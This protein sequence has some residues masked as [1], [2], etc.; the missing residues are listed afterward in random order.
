MPKYGTAFSINEA[1][2]IA[3]KI[4]YPVLIRP[5]YVLGGRG[6]EIVYDEEGLKNFVGKAALVSGEHPILID[7]FLENAYEFDVDAISDGNKV[8]IAGIMQHIEE[9]GIHSGD[10]SCVYPPYNLSTKLR[11][12]IISYTKKL[13]IELNT[14]G[15]INIQFALKDNIIYVI[16]VNPRAS[17]T[18]PF[19][20]K[21]KNVPYAKYAAQIAAGK[22]ISNFNN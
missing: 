4:S 2:I 6:M 10:S 3:N 9:A 14:V 19:I 15:L 7:A 11:E 18:I 5:S 8:E 17:R 12:T 22:K 1:I 21:V 20:S 16:E 13:A